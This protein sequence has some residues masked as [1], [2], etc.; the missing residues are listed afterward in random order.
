[1]KAAKDTQLIN[2]KCTTKIQYCTRMFFLNDIK[3]ILSNIKKLLKNNC[4]KRI[5]IFINEFKFY[6]VIII[7]LL[8]AFTFHLSSGCRIGYRTSITYPA[9]TL[10]LLP[11]QKSST[12]FSHEANVIGSRYLVPSRSP[13]CLHDRN[14]LHT[15][16]KGE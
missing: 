8:I 16:R 9:S 15:E 2:K 14:L 10:P 4:L 6:V 11:P 7:P 12:H 1:M 3:E 13:L 5:M